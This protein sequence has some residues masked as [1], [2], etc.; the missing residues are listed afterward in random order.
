MDNFEDLQT[1]AQVGREWCRNQPRLVY[2]ESA[3]WTG[4]NYLFH[5]EKRHHDWRREDWT[6]FTPPE[7]TRMVDYDEI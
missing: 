6:V 1:W 7:E 3:D 2:Y 5:G 4:V